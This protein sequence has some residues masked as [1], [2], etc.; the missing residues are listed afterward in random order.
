MRIR[1]AIPLLAVFLLAAWP[2]A[3]CA[4]EQSAKGIRALAGEAYVGTVIARVTPP[5]G[6]GVRATRRSGPASAS[7]GEDGRLVVVGNIDRDA[8]AGFAADGSFGG[9]GWSGG[10]E[11]VELAIGADGGI[12]GGGVAGGNRMAIEGRM[13]ERSLDLQFTIQ[14]LADSAGGFPAGTRFQFEYDLRRQVPGGGQQAAA[15]EGGCRKVEY[16]L[17]LVPNLS[18]G[19]MGMVRVPECIR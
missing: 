19:P 15:G 8:D 17:K 5:E 11:G 16:R 2:L 6:S 7:L 3:G 13:A 4:A 18:G 14:L 1:F 12:R 10:S 9:G